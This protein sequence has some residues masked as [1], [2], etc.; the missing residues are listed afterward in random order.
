MGMHFLGDCVDRLVE[1]FD[2]VHC[3]WMGRLHTLRRCELLRRSCMCALDAMM[4]HVCT[5]CN[6]AL[7]L[8]HVLHGCDVSWGIRVLPML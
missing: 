5:E 3:S 6:N 7:C 8:Q 1:C 2:H 4:P